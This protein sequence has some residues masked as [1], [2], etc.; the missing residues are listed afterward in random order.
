M[1]QLAVSAVSISEIYDR[2]LALIALHPAQAE[3]LGGRLLLVCGLDPVGVATVTAANVAGAATLAI[4]SDPA[5]AREAIRNGIC[6]FSVNTLD[7]ALRILKNEIRKRKPVAVCLLG[8]PQSILAEMAERG[9]QPDFAAIPPVI[10]GDLAA[11]FF[12]RGAH[13]FPPVA[14]TLPLACWSVA[15]QQPI[16]LLQQIDKL[17]A[18]SLSSSEAVRHRWLQLAPRYLGRARQHCVGMTDE[19]WAAFRALL[20]QSSGEIAAGLTVTRNGEAA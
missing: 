6:D 3:G 4:E 19:E 13:P 14:A 12:A 17:A 8:V 1:H 9:V 5:A 2:Y 15:A 18:A 20:R 10:P 7:E 16:T 11:T